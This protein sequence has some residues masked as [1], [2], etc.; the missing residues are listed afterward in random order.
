MIKTM[1]VTIHFK[2]K[3]TSKKQNCLC[4]LYITNYIAQILTQIFPTTKRQVKVLSCVKLKTKK[5]WIHPGKARRKSSQIEIS[6][7]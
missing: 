6:Y 4:K 2:E 7:S 1:T 5:D 3:H